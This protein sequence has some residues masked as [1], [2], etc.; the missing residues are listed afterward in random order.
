MIRI[1]LVKNSVSNP[2]SPCELDLLNDMCKRADSCIGKISSV[3]S[4]G[5]FDVLDTSPIEE[6]GFEFFDSAFF[7]EK[8]VVVHVTNYSLEGNHIVFIC[9]GF[10]GT[11]NASYQCYINCRVRLSKDD[12]GITILITQIKKQ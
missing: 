5:T 11:L 7:Y 9:T 4:M 3:I 6:H 10:S 1:Q 2:F 12:S 8:G